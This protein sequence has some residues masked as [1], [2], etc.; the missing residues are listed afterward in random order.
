MRFRIIILMMFMLFVS[1]AHSQNNY[2]FS[3]IDIENGLSHNQINSILKDS[4]GF[5][6][7]GTMSGL[8]RYDGHSFKVF[9][10]QPNDSTSLYN[11]FINSLYGLPDGKI[12]VGTGSGAC[13]YNSYTEKFDSSSRYLNSLG[14]PSAPITNIE[15]G[16]AGRYWFLYDT[17]GLYLYSNVEKKSKLFKRNFKSDSTEKITSIGETKDGK[18]WLVYQ[19][20][21]L[22]RY[23]LKSNKII[24]SSN[25]LQKL[26]KTTTAY[27]FFIDN[28]GDLWL[29]YFGNGVFLFSPWDNSIRQFSESSSPSRL[30]SNLVTKIVQ[31]D[32]GLIWVATDHGGAN[33]IDKKRR[34]RL[35][36]PARRRG[37]GRRG[38]GRLVA[39]IQPGQRRGARGPHGP[40]ARRAAKAPAPR[41]ARAAARLARGGRAGRTAGRRRACRRQCRGRHVRPAQAPPAP[42]QTHRWRGRRVAGRRGGLTPC[43]RP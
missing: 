19:D 23:D 6:W 25:V 14:L 39:G 30:N 38:A 36:A 33:L 28:D 4:D 16:N 20:G 8:N 2:N 34:L 21:L 37:R 5:L 26:T 11:N 17:L 24:S 10:R 35:H 32:K 22:E 29:W 40:A 3:K 31:D 41:A 1:T 18:L 7:F 27:K 12:W 13:I 43:A 42:P 15:K 9:R